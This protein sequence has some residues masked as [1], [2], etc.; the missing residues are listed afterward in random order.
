MARVEV[1][2]VKAV[3]RAPGKMH[4]VTVLDAVR[5]EVDIVLTERQ[6]RVLS[7]SLGVQLRV[8]EELEPD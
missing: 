2:T 8:G 6:A 7:V 3:Q 4:V 1:I 5:G